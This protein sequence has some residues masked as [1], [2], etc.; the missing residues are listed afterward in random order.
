MPEQ[1]QNF[2]SN[3]IELALFQINHVITKSISQNQNLIF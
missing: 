1:I 2:V 3:I